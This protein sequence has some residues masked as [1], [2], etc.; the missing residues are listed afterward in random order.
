MEGTTIA[1]LGVAY[2]GGVADT[3]RSP[4]LKLADRLKE[5]NVAAVNLTDPYVRVTG[6]DD[7]IHS[8]EAALSGSDAVVLVTDHPEYGTLEPGTFTE[9]RNGRVIVDTRAMIDVDQW[10][11]AGFDVHRV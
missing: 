3:R 9:C 5:E 1:L 6:R 4:S 11:A 8:L 7:E 10:E 2:K